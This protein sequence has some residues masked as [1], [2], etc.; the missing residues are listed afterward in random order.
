[1]ELSADPSGEVKS[2]ATGSLAGWTFTR[3]WYYWMASGPRIP[4]DVA[5]VFWGRHGGSAR[6]GGDGGWRMPTNG[7]YPGTGSYHIDTPAGLAAF[8]ELIRSLPQPGQAE[9]APGA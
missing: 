3:A 8:A 1:M 2:R 4:V 5:Q 7:G 6:A 9:P